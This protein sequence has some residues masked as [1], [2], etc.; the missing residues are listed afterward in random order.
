MSEEKT[1]IIKGLNREKEILTTALVQ[2]RDSNRTIAT[3]SSIENRLEEIDTK[4][5]SLA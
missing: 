5:T 2:L 1:L 3:R 4:L